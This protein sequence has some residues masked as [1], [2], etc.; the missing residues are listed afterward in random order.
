LL[1]HLPKEQ[2]PKKKIEACERLGCWQKQCVSINDFV[3]LH[4]FKLNFTVTKRVNQMMNEACLGK[5]REKSRLKH[6]HSTAALL[7]GKT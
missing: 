7:R 5:R 3:L 1:P 6:R 4:F 2:A